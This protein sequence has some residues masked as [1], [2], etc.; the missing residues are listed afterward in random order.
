MSI[1]CLYWESCLWVNKHESLFRQV[2]VQKVQ[3]HILQKQKK[4]HF[5]EPD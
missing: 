5:E 4:N 1:I 3:I 2:C